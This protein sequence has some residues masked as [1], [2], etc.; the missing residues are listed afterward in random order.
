MFHSYW[1]HQHMCVFKS[2]VNCLILPDVSLPVPWLGIQCPLVSTTS[3]RNWNRKKSKKMNTQLYLE[4]K[5]HYA[6]T[7]SSHALGEEGR[8]AFICF[9]SHLS[10]SAARVLRMQSILFGAS[11]WL[12]QWHSH[13]FLAFR[14]DPLL[15]LGRRTADV[16]MG[17]S[18]AWTKTSVLSY[19]SVS[20]LSIQCVLS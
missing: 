15:F 17:F 10:A 18:E 9:F 3:T 19:Q 7:H 6:G 2:N 4:V 1:V 8:T 13:S 11:L 20:G 16:E 12:G 5:L 14:W